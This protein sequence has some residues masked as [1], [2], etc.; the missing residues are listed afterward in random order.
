[1]MCAMRKA[2]VLSILFLAVLLAVAVIAEAQ[3][4]KKVSRIGYVSLTGN[5]SNQGPYVEALRQGLRDLGYI[6]GEIHRD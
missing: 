2:G 1:M 6:E 4:P 5:A 3:Q